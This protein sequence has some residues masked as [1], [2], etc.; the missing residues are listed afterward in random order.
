[1]NTVYPV[2]DSIEPVAG[3]FQKRLFSFWILSFL[4]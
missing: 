2:M 3:L 4:K 1:M